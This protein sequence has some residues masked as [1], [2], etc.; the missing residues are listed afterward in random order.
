MPGLPS[1]LLRAFDRVDKALEHLRYELVRESYS[2]F[3]EESK[4]VEA[5]ARGV[6][7]IENTVDREFRK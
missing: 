5:L 1:N 2:D 4:K 3:Y 7:E 6:N